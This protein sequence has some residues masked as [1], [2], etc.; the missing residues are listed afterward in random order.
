MCRELKRE[1]VWVASIRL[2]I[3][4]GRVDVES[5]LEESNLERGH[6]RTVRDVLAT[7]AEREV[8]VPAPDHERTGRYLPG[9]VLHDA[10]PEPRT[11][12]NVSES[13]VHR[14]GQ[15]PS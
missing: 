4:R 12:L 3:L 11:E 6:A 15:S 7:L 14:W 1:P 2:A 5:V 8:V 13:G 9:P 10:A